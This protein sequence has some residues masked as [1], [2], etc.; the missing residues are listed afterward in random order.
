MMRAWV[1]GASR[2]AQPSII[3]FLRRGIIWEQKLATRTPWDSPSVSIH[4]PSKGSHSAGGTRCALRMVWDDLNIC[5]LVCSSVEFTFGPQYLN[6][7]NPQTCVWPSR[8]SI[9][10]HVFIVWAV[11]S[12]FGQVLI[13]PI[14]QPLG[15]VQTR[16]RSNNYELVLMDKSWPPTRLV[17]RPNLFGANYK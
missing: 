15:A 14:R 6:P 4:S 3:S 7:N 12:R 10:P 2:P 17:G 13:L 16:D 9:C 5:A 1:P 11:I 8:A